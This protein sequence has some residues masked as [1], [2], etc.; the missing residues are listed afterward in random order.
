[1][2]KKQN[3]K[4]NITT[5]VALGVLLAGYKVYNYV[6]DTSPKLES[7]LSVKTRESDNALNDLRKLQ[8]FA[9]NIE[10]IK[11]ELA[12]LNL[13]LEAVLEHMPRTFDL[14]NLLRKLSMLS[15][16]SGVILSTFK[17]RKVEEK[18]GFYSTTAIDFEMRG[19]YT[20][21]LMFFDQLSRLKRI[22]NIENIKIQNSDRSVAS[23]SGS[24]MASTT[25]TIKTY[26]FSE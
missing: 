4:N 25:G 10:T 26:R 22:V 24:I 16:N 13:Q 21:T 3:I 1:M 11:K 19:S 18:V 12:E 20:Q 6:S 17:P 14:S 23:K 2:K 15:Q 9:E 7:Q 5:I 8:M